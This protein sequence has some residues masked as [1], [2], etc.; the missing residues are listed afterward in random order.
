VEDNK[1]DKKEIEKSSCHC[2]YCDD[3][4]CPE[5]GEGS[6]PCSVSLRFCSKCGAVLEKD[7]ERCP[8]CGLEVK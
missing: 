3:P 6:S 8:K 1:K 5:N 2:P 4:I 7:A